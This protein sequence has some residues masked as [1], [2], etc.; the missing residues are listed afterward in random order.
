[1]LFY[2]RAGLIVGV[3]CGTFVSTGLIKFE[4]PYFIFSHLI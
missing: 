4:Q 2:L 1:M 3:T